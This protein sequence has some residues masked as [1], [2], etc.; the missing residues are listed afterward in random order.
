MNLNEHILAE[1]SSIREHLGTM[2]TTLVKQE[3]NLAEHMRRTDLLETKV[4]KSDSKITKITYL[5]LIGSGAASVY[6]WPVV[7]ELLRFAL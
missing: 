1:L 2:N 3:S 7:R 6:Y 5:L 4:T